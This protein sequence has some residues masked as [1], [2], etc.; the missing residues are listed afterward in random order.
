MLANV[1]TA[2]GLITFRSRFS[3]EETAGRLVAAVERRGLTV[4][5][6]IDHAAAAERVGL[7]LDPT[8]VILFGN[9]KAGTP[10]MQSRQTIG[11][12]LPLK[13]LIWRDGEGVT[14]VSC[15][16]PA[17]LAQRHGIDDNQDLL[18]AMTEG[19]TAIAREAAGAAEP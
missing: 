17:Y 8:E 14:W 19:L 15:N 3:P 12:D 9:P 5:A 7:R 1:M 18:A 11:I 4:L 16:D 13:A 6:R 2:P 10:L